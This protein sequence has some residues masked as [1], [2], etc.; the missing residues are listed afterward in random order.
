MYLDLFVASYFGEKNES[1]N[2]LHGQ[3]LYYETGIFG[4]S[5]TVI[6]LFY[7]NSKRLLIMSSKR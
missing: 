5:T 3:V 1:E 7:N 6:I 2:V 4:G